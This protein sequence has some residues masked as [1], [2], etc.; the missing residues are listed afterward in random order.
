MSGRAGRG[1]ALGGALERSAPEDGRSQA[2]L[3]ADRWAV[4]F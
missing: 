4:I 1:S 2:L 3:R